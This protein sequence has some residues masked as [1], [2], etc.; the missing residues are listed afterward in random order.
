VLD[1]ANRQHLAPRNGLPGSNVAKRLKGIML[2]IISDLHLTDGSSGETIKEGA[3]RAF[4]E[5]LRDLAYD[6]SWRGHARYEPIKELHLVLLGDILDVIRSVKWC[7]AQ[8]RPWSDVHDPRLAALVADIN[9]EILKHNQN[10]LRVLHDLRLVT[11][12]PPATPGGTVATVS[13]E[14]E[15]KERVPVKV[16]IYYLVGNHDWFYHLPG[17]SFDAIRQSV[18]DAIGL[19][20]SASAPFAHDPVEWPVLMQVFLE[21]HVFA[22][23]GD[24]YDSLNYEGERNASSFGDAMV[25]ELLNRFP[26]VVAARLGTRLSQE[27][28]AG[29][30]ELDNVRPLEIVP[31]WVDGLL[32][33]TCSAVLAD[34]IKHIWNEMA[35]EFLKLDFV[36]SRT[37][38]F[39]RFGLKLSRGFSFSD[40]S[41][42]FLRFRARFRPEVFYPNAFKETAF[43]AQTSRFIVY[44]HTHRHEIVPLRSLNVAG[45]PLDQIYINSGTW[46]A[47][48]EL[49][50][51]SI[52]DEQFVGYDVMT[53]L[54]FFKDDE[55]K[56]RGFESWS[57]ALASSA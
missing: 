7:A 22:R 27:C 38:F 26:D 4:R 12:L 45:V 51:F 54:A 24:I 2:V 16:N 11:T 52:A 6:A 23:H 53:Y 17:P 21:H 50:Q 29:L 3:F 46:R 19:A 15:A 35:S 36:K 25:I 42:L 57:G 48:H 37:P 47:V 49:A 39:L 14:P 41:R 56:G 20:N 30:K 18:V 44:G 9:G 33:R 5:H 28:R 8:I 31:V 1:E 10:S 13:R 40:V 34:E 32:R 43:K 55:R